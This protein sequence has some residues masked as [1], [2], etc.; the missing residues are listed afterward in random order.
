MVSFPARYRKTVLQIHSPPSTEVVCCKCSSCVCINFSF[1]HP[2]VIVDA[3]TLQQ[4][5]CWRVCIVRP[6]HNLYWWTSQKVESKKVQ[7]GRSGL[8]TAA[9]LPIVCLAPPPWQAE[10]SHRRRHRPPH[11]ACPVHGR[12]PGGLPAHPPGPVC[13]TPPFPN[14]SVPRSGFPERNKPETKCLQIISELSSDLRINSDH[15]NRPPPAEGQH[16]VLHP[17][18]KWL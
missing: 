17:D 1:N 8:W 7:K 12:P 15:P 6:I 3:S 5:Y 11:P 14:Y 13:P 16:K 18:S 9:V 4:T 2:P 10:Q